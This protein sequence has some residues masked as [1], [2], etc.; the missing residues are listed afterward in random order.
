M[1]LLSVPSISSCFTSVSCYCIVVVLFEC[2]IFPGIFDRTCLANQWPFMMKSD[3]LCSSLIS[4]R[5]FHVMSIDQGL[6]NYA[7]ALS[8][9]LGHFRLPNQEKTSSIT[10]DILFKK[11]KSSQRPVAFR[12]LIEPCSS[13]N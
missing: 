4:S 9:L 3:T 13:I 12:A 10:P 5:L 2:G 6:V 8:L 11:Q 1:S 7:G